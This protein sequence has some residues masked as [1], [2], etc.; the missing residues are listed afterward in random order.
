MRI[1]IFL[2]VCG[3]LPG[4]D[5]CVWGEEVVAA[6]FTKYLRR[7]PKVE[8]V[9]YY[10][11]QGTRKFDQAPK[12]LDV[13]I[14]LD[15]QL[16]MD[17]SKCNVIQYEI[18]DLYFG[19]FNYYDQYDWRFS[20]GRRFADKPRACFF[21]TP[22]DIEKFK[23]TG[24]PIAYDVVFAGNTVPGQENYIEP[25]MKADKFRCGIFGCF[26]NQPV[27]HDELP[28]IY[29]TSKICLN[30]HRGD[31]IYF[32]MWSNRVVEVGACGGFMISDDIAVERDVFQGNIVT[33]TGGDDVV[34][35]VKY[36]LTHED[37]R[38]DKAQKFMEIVRANFST[39]KAV[40]VQMAK[41][42]EITG[43]G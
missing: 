2:N 23:P 36:Y 21:P 29:S 14:H 22:A 19:G 28:R 20:Y 16:P 33:T 41:L 38:K 9:E 5:V 7:H 27:N 40:E 10:G 3:T 8:F 1:G 39:E 15:P 42:L 32:D 31:F 30:R 24:L 43:K 37:E 17:F 4:K 12:D 34:D 26:S 6:D 25:V 11:R 18:S 35:K 13:V